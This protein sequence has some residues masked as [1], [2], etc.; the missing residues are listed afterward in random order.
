MLWIVP[1]VKK[2]FELEYILSEN[3]RRIEIYVSNFYTKQDKEKQKRIKFCYVILQVD[4][5]TYVINI[6][7]SDCKDTCS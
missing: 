3:I 7:E 6:V 2:L 4:R 5:N 1:N